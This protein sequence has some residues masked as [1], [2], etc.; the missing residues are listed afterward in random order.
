MFIIAVMRGSGFEP[1][2]DLVTLCQSCHRMVHDLHQQRGGN[3]AV[4]TAEALSV[5]RGDPVEPVRRKKK[6]GGP[7]KRKK[8]RGGVQRPAVGT[9]Q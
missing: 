9:G 6:S 2:S 4:V 3:L 5:L 1:L 7:G 8:K